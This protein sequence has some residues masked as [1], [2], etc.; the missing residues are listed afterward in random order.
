MVACPLTNV[1]WFL[2]LWQLTSGLNNT[3]LLSDYFEKLQTLISPNLIKKN[4]IQ[5]DPALIISMLLNS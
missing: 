2:Y 1:S 4:T 5:E 3:Q